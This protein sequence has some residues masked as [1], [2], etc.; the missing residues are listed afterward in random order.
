MYHG[1][2]CIALFYVQLCSF[3]ETNIN[4]EK[5][6]VNSLTNQLDADNKGH[7]EISTGKLLKKVIILSKKCQFSLLLIT[8]EAIIGL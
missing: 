8:Q 1:L 3:L 5:L 4:L 2:S 6:I 7:F